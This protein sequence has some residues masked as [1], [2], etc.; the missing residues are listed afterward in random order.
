MGPGPYSPGIIPGAKSSAP[1][2]WWRSKGPVL[3]FGLSFALLMALYYGVAVTPWF[4][5][6]LYQILRWNAQLSGAVLDAL[7]QDTRTQD[8]LIRSARFAVNIRR[9]CDA[10]EP[11]WYFSAAILAFP[12]PW[13]PK[14]LG[15][16]VG[17]VLIA[18]ANILRIVSLFLLGVYFPRSFAVAHLE[19][20]PALLILLACALW[21]GWLVWLRRRPRHAA[22]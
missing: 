4:D 12:S 6:V 3:R 19:I 1:L 7:G 5:Q 15:I 21:V 8:T 9:G 17:A 13:L 16:T 20:W 14:A 2:R 22:S 11:I 10:V 18:A